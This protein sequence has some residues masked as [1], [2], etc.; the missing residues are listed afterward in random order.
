MFSYSI[1]DQLKLALPR[2][3]IDASAL[4][5]LID[6]DR[7]ELGRWLPW[8]D[9][10]RSPQDE[11]AFLQSV[12]SHFAQG[13]S[14]NT[15]IWVGNAPA[16]M[17]SFNGFHELSQSADIGYWLGRQ[18]RGRGVMT[19]AVRG[20]CRLGFDEY[21]LNKITIEA[22]VDNHTSNAVAEHAGFHLDGTLRAN[23]LL[24]DGAHDGHV[25]SLLKSE[26]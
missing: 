20:L 23:E 15:V 22:A 13:T 14:L 12:L 19:Q 10:L 4:S 6:A 9:T 8:V 11:T 1:N 7:D 2:P 21:A 5:T 16:G 25:W 26:F 18:F 3:L 24:A 17:I